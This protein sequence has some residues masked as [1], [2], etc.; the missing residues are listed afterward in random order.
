[1]HKSSRDKAL[2]YL[3][4]SSEAHTDTNNHVFSEYS[5]THFNCFLLMHCNDI[6]MQLCFHIRKDHVTFYPVDEVISLNYI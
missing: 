6:L 4:S 2:A 1:M 3:N 5:D